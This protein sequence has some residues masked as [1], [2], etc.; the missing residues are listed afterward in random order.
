MSVGKASIRRAVGAE[1]KPVE[2]VPE[3]ENKI[4]TVA[5]EKTPAK[6]TAAKP[7]AKAPAKK[8]AAK[9]PPKATAKAPA[10]APVKKVP[11]KK[12]PAAPEKKA[13]PKASFGAVSLTED[14]PY[15]LL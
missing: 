2:S 13:E 7:A 1:N 8:P 12:S 9:T 3:V 5:S 14:L 4:E 6:K 11:A 15:Y 10:K